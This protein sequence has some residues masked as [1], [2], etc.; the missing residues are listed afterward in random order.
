M[1]C[2]LVKIAVVSDSYAPY[3]DGVARY[4][5]RVVQLLSDRGHKVLIIG[6]G[7]SLH[8]KYEFEQ[9]N[10][11]IVRNPSLWMLRLNDYYPS[12]PSRACA[13][14]ISWA[15]VVFSPSLAPLGIYSIIYASRIR[16]PIAFFCVHDELVLL[17]KGIWLPLPKRLVSMI[18]RGLYKRCPV[19]FFA[20]QRFREKIL[21][22]GIPESK[23]VYDPYGIEFD[24]FSSGDKAIGRKKLG[25]PPNAKAVLYLG[26]MSE[27]KN[28]RTLIATIPQV[29]K[30]FSNL[31]YV[32]AG[33]GPKFDEYRKEAMVAGKASGTKVIFTGRVAFNDLPNTY[34][35]GDV[36]VHPSLHEAQSFTV[37]EAM[38]TGEP[39]ITAAEEGKY[40]FLKEGV[41]AEFVEDVLDCD[42]LSNKI[43]GLL[44]DNERRTKMG[45]NAIIIARQHSWDAHIDKL[46]EGFMTAIKAR[47]RTS[48]KQT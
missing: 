16:K 29:A 11:G 13:E 4:L 10:V 1:R 14:V 47:R 32:F 7:F 22:L 39:A 36:F 5:N 18:I 15:D 8:T 25:I 17:G 34:A 28:V 40:S 44:K 6:P 35:I 42:E 33:H 41:N 38:C 46:E 9:N 12:L 3:V 45:K 43:I 30:H 2:P 31:Y 23:L 21:R 26:R 19:I 24:F 27:E 37:L 48:S 20:T